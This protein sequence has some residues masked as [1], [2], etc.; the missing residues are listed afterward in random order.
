MS[1]LRAVQWQEGRAHRRTPRVAGPWPL[2]VLLLLA[3]ASGGCYR[4]TPIEPTAVHPREEV[5]VRVTDAA[6]ERLIGELGVY[7][8]VLQGQ[9][10]AERPDSLSLSILI[11]RQYGGMA[12]ENTRQVLFL[13]PSEVVAV[14]RRQI[15]RGKTALATAGVLVAA[16]LL[17]R[18]IVHMADPNPVDDDVPSPPPAGYLGS[19]RIPIR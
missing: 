4:Y 10:S 19:I 16:G 11:G 3:L 18:S 17:I 12:L 15:S 6:S 5:Q 8:G 7:T 13:G 2:R 9:L 14:R 1:N